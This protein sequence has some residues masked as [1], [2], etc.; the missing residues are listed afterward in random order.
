VHV[1]TDRAAERRADS[2]LQGSDRPE[3]WRGGR[4]PGFPERLSGP[5]WAPASASIAWAVGVVALAML[6][7]YQMRRIE[8]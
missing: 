1:V 7:T 6:A 4:R 5:R 8:L 2:V 3:C